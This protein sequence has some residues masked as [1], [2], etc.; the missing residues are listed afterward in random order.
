MSEQRTDSEGY[1]LVSLR[2]VDLDALLDGYG[3][4]QVPSS[5]AHGP[6]ERACA[7]WEA[8]GGDDL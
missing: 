1:V 3:T 6:Y 2:L 8:A 7:A 5:L 4:D